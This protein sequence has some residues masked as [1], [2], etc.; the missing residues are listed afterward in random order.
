MRAA[1]L[2]GASLVVGSNAL[3]LSDAGNRPVTKV[4]NLLKDMQKELETERD[5]DEKIYNK[6]A[7][8]AKGEI[9]KQTTEITTQEAEIKTQQAKIEKNVALSAKMA[10]EIKNEKAE[11]KSTQESLEKATA[12]RR[13]ELAEFNEVEKDLLQSISSLKGAIAVLKKHNSFMQLPNSDKGA[14]SRAIE[15]A[16]Y[17]HRDLVETVMTPSQQTTLKS[18]LSAAPSAGSY[19][20]QSGQI[21]GILEQLQ[22]SMQADLDTAQKEEAAAQKSYTGMKQTYEETIA[23]LT[24]SIADKSE[25]KAAADEAEQEARVAL[26]N[27]KEALAAAQAAL[28]AARDRKQANE[29]EYQARSKSRADEITAVSEAIGILSGDDAHASFEGT[30]NSF[31]QVRSQTRNSASSLLSAAA[32]K[33]QSPKLAALAL[34]AKLDAFTKVKA[35]IDQMVK[36]LLAKKDAEIKKR[37]FCIASINE[38]ELSQ[39]DTERDIEKHTAAIATLEGEID[40]L[41]KNIAT[42]EALIAELQKDVKDAGID[43]SN[44]NKEFQATI[45][46]QRETKNLLQQAITVLQKVYK[47][48]KT[49]ALIQQGPA[50]FKEYKQNSGKGGVIG[51]LNQIVSDTDVMITEAQKD[52][53]A[54]Q[55]A[56]ENFVKLSNKQIKDAQASID[57]DK[58][59]KA[60]KEEDKIAA[61]QSL[62]S[63][64]GK[65]AQL[66]TTNTNLHQDCDFTLKNFTVRQEARDGEV[67]A[68]RQAKAILNGMNA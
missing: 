45:A 36:D 6:V 2:A 19:A 41:K 26:K 58:G 23:T 3:S 55:A 12:L 20:N 4:V 44:E 46:T 35:A 65:L 25:R 67:E 21:F 7:C 53:Q 9:E 49:P 22:E 33:F 63:S 48:T 39:K 11:L 24:K 40:E 52:E 54:S 29:Q 32:E 1:V 64:N 62:D 17:N 16:M 57:S 28:A 50:G 14:V 61:E 13:K 18:F 27:A 51:L 15:N 8:W 34:Q 30:F 59:T 5:N 31:V 47:D 68:L 42:N 60:S 38:N 66:K 56:Y 37:D 10:A 43:R